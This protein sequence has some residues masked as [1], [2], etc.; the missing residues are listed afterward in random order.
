MNRRDALKTF[1]TVPA[2]GLIPAVSKKPPEPFASFRCQDDILEVNREDFA[3]CSMTNHIGD[4]TGLSFSQS[5]KV[6]DYV[7]KHLFGMRTVSLRAFGF[8]FEFMPTSKML[9]CINS[10]K[11]A[12]PS[13]IFIFGLPSQSI[14]PVRLVMPG[15]IIDLNPETPKMPWGLISSTNQ[16]ATANRN[17]LSVEF[18]GLNEEYLELFSRNKHMQLEQG[19]KVYR[20]VKFTNRNY[21]ANRHALTGSRPI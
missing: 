4:S 10:S 1:A 19:D 7:T 21:V 11:Y 5:D 6:Y 8:D 14:E 13:S 9:F 3:A 20:N 16:R 2:L 12:Q 17:F 15:R 18:H